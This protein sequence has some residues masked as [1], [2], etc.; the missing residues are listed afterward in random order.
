MYRTCRAC[1]TT[2][3]AWRR[4]TLRLRGTSWRMRFCPAPR[5]CEAGEGIGEVV[6]FGAFAL[7]Y[8]L[9]E[10]VTLALVGAILFLALP[11]AWLPLGVWVYVRGV[12]IPRR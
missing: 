5:L 8:L 4:S 12:G 1:A 2:F 3:R 11:L 10:S 7:L 9:C 6:E